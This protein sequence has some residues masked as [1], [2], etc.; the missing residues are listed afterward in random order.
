MVLGE[1][2]C[3]MV[4]KTRIPKAYSDVDRSED[5]RLAL[6]ASLGARAYASYPLLDGAE[7]LGTLSFDS[8]TRPIITESELE[9]LRLTTDLLAVALAHHRDHAALDRAHVDVRALVGQAQAL[10]S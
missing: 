5:E 7:L 9:V 2:V 1:A 8:R 6:A 3:G 4:A 10:R